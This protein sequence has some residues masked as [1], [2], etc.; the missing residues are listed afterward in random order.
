MRLEMVAVGMFLV[1]AVVFPARVE[2]QAVLI[3]RCAADRLSAAQVKPRVELARWCALTRNVRAPD[4]TCSS[5]SSSSSDYAET[6]FNTNPFGRNVY[7]SS[8]DSGVNSTYLWLLYVSGAMSSTVDADG[9]CKWLRPAER[10]K[11]R[12]FYP[13][14]GSH[15]DLMNSSNRQL[16][17]HPTQFS[18]DFYLDKNGTQRATG[19]D[20]YIN[21]YC[22]P[23]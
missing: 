6:D 22:E 11:Q 3:Q 18:C 5:S 4:W 2:A 13:V 19:Y 20:F 16:F 21:G 1:G 10:L 7:L 8:V 23:V 14:Y 17:F 12:P 9:Y 15:H